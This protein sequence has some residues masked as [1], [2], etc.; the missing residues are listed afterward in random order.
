MYHC[1]LSVNYRVELHN[2]TCE[3]KVGLYVREDSFMCENYDLVYTPTEIVVT[4]SLY[5]N[6]EFL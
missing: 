1:I 3:G 6:N 2:V 4:V 5:F